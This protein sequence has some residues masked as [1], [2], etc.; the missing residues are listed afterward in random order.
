LKQKNILTEH[1]SLALDTGNNI[2]LTANAG[3]GK[4]FVLSKR[5][6]EIALKKNIPL[7]KIAAIT[8]TEKAA[9]EL[10]KK[11]AGQLEDMAASTAEPQMHEKL[12]R[13]RRN[14][15]S[16]NISTI[17]S[18]CINL[19]KEYPVEAGLDANFVPIDTTI[20]SELT[21][22]AVES[23]IRSALNSNE[24]APRIKALIRLFSSRTIFAKEL[25]WMIGGRKN[26]LELKNKLYNADSAR[27]A[28]IFYQNFINFAGDY[29]NK[30]LPGFISALEIVIS[31]VLSDN[32]SNKEAIAASGIPSLLKKEKN[33]ETLLNILSST[34]NI[35]CTGRSLKRLFIRKVEEEV[36]EEI[37]VIE[38]YLSDVKY[39]C[40]GDNHLQAEKLLAETGYDLLY[41]FDKALEKYDDKKRTRGYLDFED[42][43]LY[44]KDLLEDQTVRESVWQKFDYIMIDEYQ[45]TNEI[46]YEIFLPILDYLKRGNL[47]VVGDEK[48][49]IYMFRD[50]ELGVFERTKEQ[51]KNMD[52]GRLLLLPDSFRM[53][54][55]ICLF[56]NYVFSRLFSSPDITFNE[57]AHSDLVCARENPEGGEIAFLLED[58]T[59][60]ADL[61]SLKLLELKKNKNI[62]WSDAAVLSRKRK[63]FQDLEEGFV[64]YNIPYQIMGG[65]NFYQRQSIYDIFNYFSF[66]LDNNND[67]ALAGILRSPFFN[68][69]DSKLYE[70]SLN[71]GFNF[72]QKLL[73]SEDETLITV[74]DKLKSMVSSAA[75]TDAPALLRIML[76]ESDF[77]SYLAAGTNGSQETANVNKLV[78]ITIDYYAKGFRTLY[79]YV[80]FLRSSIELTEDESQAVIADDSNTVKIMT[81]HMAKGLE[82]PVVFIFKAAEYA[83]KNTVRQKSLMVNREIGLLTKVPLNEN[84]YEDY[85]SVP[86]VDLNNFISLK[87][88]KAELKRLL[89]VAVTRAKDYLYI[90]APKK[91]KYSDDSFM[92][93]LMDALEEEFSPEG[94]SI[95]GTLGFLKRTGDAYKRKDSKLHI[96]IPVYTSLDEAGEEKEIKEILQRSLLTEHIADTA[97]EE[98]ISATRFS[99]YGHCPRKYR[100]TYI[101]GLLPL[102]KPPVYG[103]IDDEEKDEEI[104]AGSGSIKGRIIHKLLQKESENLD[105]ALIGNMVYKEEPFISSKAADEIVCEIINILKNFFAS[106][107]YKSVKDLDGKNEY[108]VYYRE[109]DYIL[110]GIIDKLIL[111]D[112]TA[113]IIDY[114]TD[115]IPADKISERAS[116]YLNQ[117]KFYSYIIWNT[118]NRSLNVSFKIVF[119]R[120]PDKCFEKNESP[121]E[122][123]DT[124]VQVNEMIQSIRN[125][126]FR[127]EKNHCS[128]C[129]YSADYKNCIKKDNVI[130]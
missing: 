58:E 41:F 70:I 33:T 97:R 90:T 111:E 9:S 35:I 68:L 120:H 107:F 99:T 69:T 57:V 37:R 98:I 20:S 96:D 29:F 25:M 1:Q 39:F 67:A 48:Q 92:G 75:Y 93:L 76:N 55:N 53:S 18:F 127:P 110:Y 126:N 108:E 123:L 42:I 101:D 60:E 13:I 51:I 130:Q 61:I 115:D 112:N 59:Y 128:R 66:L 94:F 47:F 95:S 109:N 77:I 113:T 119:V 15:V 23:V 4:T 78:N 102:I 54:Q 28:E 8:F 10:Y 56:T 79:D 125:N 19:L 36:S 122:L 52:N 7:R 73:A 24:D 6:L 117:L 83:Q 50:A 32:K 30:N 116:E 104:S 31:K 81:I 45:D 64:K 44:T 5:F 46:Q 63:S 34:V 74:K 103:S 91:E 118:F 22:I 71:K 88:N 100:F 2:A 17:H 82:F 27:T 14:L 49:S 80:Q 105:P 16:A 85:T 62:N 38:N 124:G 129:I 106:P 114:K 21:E 65:R 40:I 86:A 89:Y 72:Y 84:Y 87:K 12:N 3:S 121:R 11:I 43:L 26:V